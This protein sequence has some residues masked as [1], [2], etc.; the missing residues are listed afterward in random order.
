MAV[1]SVAENVKFI[2][3][4][5]GNAISVSRIVAVVTPDSA[6]AKQL[7]QESRSKGLLVDATSGK[8][9]RSIFIMDSDHVV[10]S[11]VAA[12]T[13]LPRL[14]ENDDKANEG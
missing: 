9:T 4:G 1:K 8:K 12:E 3:I 11:A 5:G 2:S 7:I 10:I 6:P 13:V 14:E